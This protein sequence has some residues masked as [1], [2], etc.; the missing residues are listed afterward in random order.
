MST[1]DESARAQPPPDDDKATS[2]RP[3]AG[4]AWSCAGGLVGLD[5]QSETPAI[6]AALAERVW[7]GTLLALCASVLI[8]LDATREEI[9]RGIDNEMRRM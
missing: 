3:L 8:T 2:L 7:A 4:L 9:T 6:D 1:G 5:L